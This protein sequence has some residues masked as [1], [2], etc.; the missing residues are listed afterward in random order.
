MGFRRTAYSQC[1]TQVSFFNAPSIECRG[2]AVTL[3]E[4]VLWH[5]RSFRLCESFLTYVHK[6]LSYHLPYFLKIEHIENQLFQQFLSWQTSNHLDTCVIFIN[7]QEYR[8]FRQNFFSVIFEGIVLLS[9]KIH[10]VP[11]MHIFIFRSFIIF[12][13]TLEALNFHEKSSWYR[14]F[15]LI[16]MLNTSRALLN[17]RILFLDM[18]NCIFRWFR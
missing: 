7:I 2:L 13:V 17:R 16:T 15:F 12:I 3:L 4:I 18:E 6:L 8:N 5:L 1:H 14:L 11:E 9:A 10:N